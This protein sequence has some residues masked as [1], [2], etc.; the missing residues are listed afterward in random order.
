MPRDPDHVLDA[1][2]GVVDE[3]ETLSADAMRWVPPESGK[4][5][6]DLLREVTDIFGPLANALTLA[7]RPL[8]DAVTRVM[9]H[10]VDDEEDE[11]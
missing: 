9:D 5:G 10:L 7:F 3:W 11:R 8:G 2:D 1:I 6:N 4:G